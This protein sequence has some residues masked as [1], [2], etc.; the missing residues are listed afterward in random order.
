M[1]R[2]AN[3]LHKGAALFASPASRGI[4]V[5]ATL[6]VGMSLSYDPAHDHFGWT[7]AAWAETGTN[8]S[9][10]LPDPVTMADAAYLAGFS[11]PESQIL[12]DI[13]DGTLAGIVIVARAMSGIDFTPE[14][15]GDTL[16]LREDEGHLLADFQRRMV[17][18]QSLKAAAEEVGQALNIEAIDGAI[19]ISGMRPAPAPTLTGGQ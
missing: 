2:F 15:Y 7:D 4:A 9:L 12:G 13:P 1:S 8:A 3:F 10:V 11:V 19:G 14:M 16:V 18:L 17:L 6:A 5:A